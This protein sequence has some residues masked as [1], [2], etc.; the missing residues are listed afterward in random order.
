VSGANMVVL[1]CTQV[2]NL[3][4]GIA[5]FYDQS[6]ELWEDMWGVSLHNTVF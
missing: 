4:Q 1:V 2:A 6:S 3:N 5:A